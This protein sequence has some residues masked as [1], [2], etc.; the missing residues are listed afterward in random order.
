MTPKP[1]IPVF[2]RIWKAI[3]IMRVGDVPM[4]ALAASAS[5]R[6]TGSYLR[7]LETQGYLACVAAANP[8]KGLPAK[9]RIKRDTGP[10]APKPLKAGPVKLKTNMARCSTSRVVE[11][12][13]NAVL[14]AWGS[15]D[16]AQLCAAAKVRALTVANVMARLVATGI[17][18]LESEG[19]WRLSETQR[20]GA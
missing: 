17:A 13:I 5:P 15:A 14:L 8:R 1:K 3:R 19:R 12:R 10:K 9:Y 18:C 20:P 2:E 4:V 16:L 11:M 7:W 6:T